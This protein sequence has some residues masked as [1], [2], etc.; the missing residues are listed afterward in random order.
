MK[1]LK[2]QVL[3]GPNVWSNYRNRLIQVRLDLE[4]MEEFPTDKIKGFCS[5]LK[6]LLPSMIE[7]EC[8][9]GKRGGF[10][11]RVERG[12][13]LGHVMEHIALEIQSMAGME[14]G[15]GRTR[16]TSTKGIYNLVFTYE[17]EEAGLYAAQAAFRIINALCDNETYDLKDDITQLKFLKRRYGL[18]PS[19]L[20]IVK[21]AEKRGIPWTRLGKN[22][23]I[24]LGYGVNQKQFQA[25]I[26]CN[27]ANTAVNI[28]GDKDA[29]KKLLAKA[30]VPVAAGDV[31][32]TI[33]G[34]NDI[35]DSIG[36]PIVIKPLNGNHG[37]GAT[38]GINN[39]DAAI[40]AFAEA[41][42]FGRY[43][44][45]EKFVSGSDFRLLVIDGKFVAA[46]KRVPAHVIGDGKSDISDLIDR[47]NSQPNRGEGHE[48]AL[49]KITC[50]H[51]TDNQLQ[52]YGYTLQ[53]IPAA[54]EI[55]YL[56][57]TANISTGG[58]AEDV[59]DEIHPENI[60]TAERIAKIV[61][62]DVCGIDIMAAN[63]TEPLRKTQGVVLEVNA[64]PGFRMHLEPSIG[65]PR[66]VAKA[67]V[68]MLYPPGSVSTVPLFAVT[69]TNGKTTTT[70]LLAHIAKTAGYCPGYTTTDG[71]YIG[72]YRIQEG[73]TT[74]PVSG[75]LILSDPT[76]DFAVLETARGGLLRGGLCF[77]QCDVGIITNIQED[78]LGLNDIEDL[79]DLANVK[80]VVARSVKT[81]GWAVLNAEDENC[82]RIANQID[83]NVAFFAFDEDLPLIQRRIKRGRP[84]AVL[85]G[86]DITIIKG[87]DRIIL[88]SVF[89][90]PLTENGH[91][92]F[93]ISNVMAAALAA[94]CYG[95]TIEL[96]REALHSFTPDY[97][98]TPGRMN[99]FDM[100]TYKVLVDYAHNPH[101]LMAM[102]DYLSHVDASRKIGIIA[103]I[104]DRREED[105]ITL[106][107][108]AA[109]MFDHIIVR[110]EH[111]LRGKTVDEINALV[112]KGI[113]SAGTKTT[114]DLIPNEPEAIAF[115]IR[116]AAPGDLIVALSDGHREVVDIILEE[117]EYIKST[118]D[119]QLLYPV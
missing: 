109:G 58:T 26:T 61:G 113:Q 45:V 37:K 71:I 69:G 85:S 76:I 19:T 118:A 57:S 89:N 2:T 103:G 18:G 23:K 27:T 20:S 48:A 87:S 116:M 92:R 9:E 8:S 15:Y 62:L 4:E 95:L 111:S 82:V 47:V 74:G 13:W 24:Q 59:T 102:K 72:D 106:A 16:S 94:Y 49:T 63:I 36:F 41:K 99:L 17:V 119:R 104:G 22:S 5:R 93:M 70:R 3:R 112:V 98:T 64:A 68:D 80:A 1:I 6:S 32:Q 33:E 91:C 34:L 30:M 78:H 90:I 55:I 81:D 100:G 97:E 96:I 39:P 12:T 77:E 60:F 11:E 42:V 51:D 14:T 29:T 50:D 75:S 65:K 35:I 54:N 105:T 86:N 88:D 7:H 46:S 79:R 52:K 21:E 66:N 38:I 117:Q 108:I 31:C 110:Q 10:F 115:A 56:K 73:D 40:D 44:V 101:G 28:A 43:V 114:Y 67:V 53:S 84:V 25:T 83:C 107:K